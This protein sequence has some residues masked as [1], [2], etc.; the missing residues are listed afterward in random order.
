MMLLG[1]SCVHCV[2][3]DHMY[4]LPLFVYAGII[5]DPDGRETI[6]FSY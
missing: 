3:K 5:G 4:A 1:G 6:R 2:L